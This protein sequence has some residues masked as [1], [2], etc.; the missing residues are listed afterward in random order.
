MAYSTKI[1][2]EVIKFFKEHA[3][4]VSTNGSNYYFFPFWIK[5]IGDGCVEMHSLGN[6]PDELVSAIYLFRE[7]GF[8]P[9]LPKE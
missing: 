4:T 3:S 8:I 7:N 5:E 6:L 1:P 2:T 9:S